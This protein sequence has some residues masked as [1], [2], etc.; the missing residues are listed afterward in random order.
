[1]VKDG[2]GSTATI[3]LDEVAGFDEFEGR[4]PV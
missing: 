2:D 1:M 4:R 3:S